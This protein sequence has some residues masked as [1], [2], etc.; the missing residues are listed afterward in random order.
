[1]S[2]LW[3]FG[4]GSLMWNPGFE[5]L[6]SMPARLEGYHRSLCIY[7]HVY[8]GTPEQPGLVLGLSSGGSAMGIAFEVAA[9]Q[10]DKV[11]DYLREREQ[12]TSVYLEHYGPL[13]LLDGSGRETGEQVEAV[14]YIADSQHKQY[15]GHL[16][17][18]QQMRYVRQGHGKAGPN[19]EYVLNTVDHLK[20]I[21]IDDPGLFSLADQLR[22]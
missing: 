22:G 7:S 12:V 21:D 19:V 16:A 15:A 9:D 2:N 13:F 4:Y 18:D 10:R 14:T 20:E 17:L 8:R 1:M 3:V 5:F 11:I 6:R